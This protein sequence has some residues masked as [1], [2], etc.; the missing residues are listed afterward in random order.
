[1]K[2]ERKQSECGWCG[3]IYA[4]EFICTYLLHKTTTIYASC[5]LMLSSS[6]LTTLTQHT[7]ISTNGK[8]IMLTL[9]VSSPKL[10]FINVNYFLHNKSLSTTTWI[11]ECTKIKY[12]KATKVSE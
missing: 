4:H 5:N 1:M 10:T 3:Y 7:C 11:I 12:V 2:K 6:A 9:H 8:N